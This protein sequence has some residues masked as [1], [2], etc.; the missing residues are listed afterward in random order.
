[1]DIG[2]GLGNISSL[3]FE[4]L[5]IENHFGIDV[6]HKM[7]N[8]ANRHRTNARIN[9]LLQD[10]SEDW[11]SLRPELKALEGKVD[12]IFSS[13][14]LQFITNIPKAAENIS[15]LLAPGGQL[16][17]VAFC[18][19]DSLH[20]QTN[21]KGTPMKVPTAQEQVNLWTDALKQA[22]LKVEQV[23]LF[24]FEETVPPMEAEGMIDSNF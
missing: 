13:F 9:F 17:T 14:V 16:Q 20:T 4:K 24:K 10:I 3:L 7:I 5:R 11:S 8:F 21:G 18:L 22:G 1:M 12:L 19:T 23:K 6:D 2:S 15:K